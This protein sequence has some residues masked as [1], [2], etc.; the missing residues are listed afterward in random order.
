VRTHT[1]KI[2][3]IAPGVVPKRVLFFSVINAMLLLATY[4]APILTAFETGAVNR[5]LHAYTGEKFSN[6][7]AG[8][9]QV[10]K[11]VQNMVL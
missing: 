1:R 10:P 6:F 7:C 8:V 5:L 2:G 4:P 11:I 3:E 9:F